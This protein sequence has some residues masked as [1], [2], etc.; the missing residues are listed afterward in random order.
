MYH[1]QCRDAAPAAGYA[2]LRAMQIIL[3]GSLK[4][5]PLA[6]LLRFLAEHGHG[7]TLDVEA[8]PKRARIFL[9][10]GRLLGAEAAGIG[11]V[12]SILVDAGMWQSGAF[13][14][15]DSVVL[16]DGATPQD[17]E[18]GPL[19]AE[20]AQRIE[21][22]KLFP[23]ATMFKVIDSPAQEQLTLTAED[24][25]L[26]IRI[27]H[28]RSFGEL[29]ADRDRFVLADTLRRLQA[30]GLVQIAQPEMKAGGDVGERTLVTPGD[31]GKLK[32]VE[33]RLPEPI[34]QIPSPFAPDPEPEPAP[35]PAAA[36]QSMATVTEQRM[37][38]ANE[39]I[40]SLTLDGAAAP[41]FVLAEESQ[42]IG[43]DA[44]NGIVVADGS[45]STR[46]ATITRTKTAFFIEDAGSRNGTFVNG[47]KVTEKRQLGD[48]DVIRLGKVIF[49][50]NIAAEI[51]RGET[52][53]GATPRG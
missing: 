14:L 31:D 6:Q 48:N 28:G 49:V 1:D 5:F 22:A 37:P 39:L 29:S 19:L 18:V 52:T 44:T 17:L 34:P 46:H 45:I 53:A 38:T 25:R 36:P 9:R 47:E 40:A 7:G 21:E 15:L 24:L 30:E 2:K 11:D 16:P 20:V 33:E 32:T 35:A 4:Q 13:T 3:Q 42:T 41:A 12:I 23:S 10:D 50:F 8:K 43:R 26:L 51:K 27:G